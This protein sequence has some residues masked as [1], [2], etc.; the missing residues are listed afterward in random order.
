MNSQLIFFATLL[1]FS[2][3]VT[4]CAS[5][6]EPTMT[7]VG[8]AST[9][10]NDD[11]VTAFDRDT[12]SYP[13]F[14]RN[15][16]ELCADCKTT[17][18]IITETEQTLPLDLVNQIRKVATSIYDEQRQQFS[19][20]SRPHLLDGKNA[21]VMKSLN[22]ALPSVGDKNLLY[23]VS[24]DSKDCLRIT[25]IEPETLRVGL[26]R[27]YTHIESPDVVRRQIALIGMD[28]LVLRLMRDLRNILGA[29]AEQFGSFVAKAVEL[30]SRSSKK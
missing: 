21:A 8:A 16:V 25:F 26:E 7:K 14:R 20:I 9:G 13:F 1:S 2:S 11:A 18:I 22:C 6:A 27:I 4:G 23:F 12:P 17:I 30:Q 3:F 10:S 5:Y 29:N 19:L 15:V 28:E 24:R